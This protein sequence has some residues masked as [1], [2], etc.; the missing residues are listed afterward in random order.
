MWL[1]KSGAKRSCEMCGLLNFLT[2]GSLHSLKLLTFVFTFALMK[3]LFFL[4][5][6][7]AQTYYAQENPLNNPVQTQT[8]L[9]LT[10]LIE[11]KAEYH[12]LT[13][14][15]RDG[16]RIKIH[17]GVD[18][19]TAENVKSKFSSMFND[20]AVYMDYQQPDFVVL[21]GDYKTKLEAF[22]SLKKIQSEFPIAFI[23]KAKINTK[24][25]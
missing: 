1:F 18:R 19:E 23:V 22:E 12:R 3:K 17:F 7:T 6:L 9:R 13:H 20:L 8:Q 10:E 4:F 21:V 15:Q 14:G 11:K 25:E 16:Y 2:F 5:A 24:K